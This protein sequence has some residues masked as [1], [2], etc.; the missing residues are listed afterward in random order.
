MSSKA[1]TRA[2]YKYNKKTYKQFNVQIKPELWQEIM[3]Y[4]KDNGI[5]RA[6]FLK[7]SL[8]QL[9]DNK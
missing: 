4:C 2:S 7:Q 9:K 1:Q 3:D 6:E 8:E 5:S